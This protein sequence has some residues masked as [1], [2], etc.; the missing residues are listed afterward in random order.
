MASI[1]IPAVALSSL[2]IPPGTSSHERIRLPGKGISRLNSYGYGDHYVTIKV[3]VPKKLSEEQKAL[4][5]NFAETEVEV[6]GSVEGVTNTS[7]GEA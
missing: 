5:L 6:N 1:M 7:T 3:R 2:Q 4:L